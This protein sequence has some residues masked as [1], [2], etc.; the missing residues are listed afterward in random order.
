VAAAGTHDVEIADLGHW[1]LAPARAR[2]VG[3]HG[4]ASQGD[5][6]ARGGRGCLANFYDLPR[7]RAAGKRDHPGRSAFP[8]RTCSRDDMATTAVRRTQPRSPR[9]RTE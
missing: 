1:T 7:D 4:R 9:S 8:A 6:A 2:P 5:R 3:G